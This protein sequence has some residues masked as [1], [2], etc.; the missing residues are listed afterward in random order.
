MSSET[1]TISRLARLA[2]VNVETVRFYERQGLIPDPPRGPGG[3]RH[4]QPDTIERIGL[5]RCAKGLGFSLA[6]IRDLLN[7]GLG[8]DTHSSGKTALLAETIAKV[9]GKIEALIALRQALHALRI[10][11]AEKA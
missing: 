1:L 10:K 9:D 8:Q 6:E 11:P 5:I 4:Y 2:S 7:L 3:C